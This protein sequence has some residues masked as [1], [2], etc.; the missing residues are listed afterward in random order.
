MGGV[1]KF[2]CVNLKKML[3]FFEKRISDA[4]KWLKLLL[5]KERGFS[6]F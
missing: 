5:N 4:K 1:S 3:F 2:W 6:I